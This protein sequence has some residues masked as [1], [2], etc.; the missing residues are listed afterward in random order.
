MAKQSF[1]Y[2]LTVIGSGAG[3]SLAAMIATKNNKKVAI[4]ESDIFGGESPNY[5]DIPTKALLHTAHLYSDAKHGDEFGLR[6]HTL[7]YNF[8]SIKAWKD[9]TIKRTGAGGNR[10]YYEAQGITTYHGEARFISPNEISINRRHISSRYFLIATGSHWTCPDIV[11]LKDVPYY[12]PK[13]ILDIMK[14]PKSLLVIGGGPAGV[15]LAQLMATFGTKVYITEISSRLLP[16]FDQ[17]V[18]NLFE[19]ILFEENGISC[20]TQTRILSVS[21]EG[22]NKRVIYSRGDVKKTIHVEEILVATGKEPNIDLGLDNA[23]I[24]YSPKGI[25]VN[26]FLQTNSK[27]IYAAGDIIGKDNSQTHT[28]LMES[29]IAAHNILNRTKISPNYEATPSIVFTQ[30]SIAHCGLSED[31]CLRRDLN[32]KKSFAPLSLLSRGNV[33]NYTDGFVKMICDKKNV[34]LGGTVVSPNASEIIHEIALAVKNE[35]TAEQVA[36]TPHAFLSWSEAVQ[37]AAERLL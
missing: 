27:H 30:P 11:G 1:D 35:L 25:E 16:H 21:K 26:D 15:E 8:H 10:K 22:L 19:R 23:A 3:G 12:T 24:N 5:G 7:G 29:R 6:T 18:G 2:D 14:L 13:T 37:I 33:N 32:I 34:I 31:D 4:I 28:A 17:E 20:L 36:N 9:R